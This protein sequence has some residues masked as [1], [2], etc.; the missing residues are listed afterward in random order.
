MYQKRG[1]V[2]KCIGGV[3]E[4]HFEHFRSE[5][6]TVAFSNA[7]ILQKEEICFMGRTF[8]ESNVKSAIDERLAIAG[9]NGIYSHSPGFEN[10]LG[11]LDFIKENY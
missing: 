10:C 2:S 6:G 3:L 11:I 1:G 5:L 7:H 4:V 9:I 8:L